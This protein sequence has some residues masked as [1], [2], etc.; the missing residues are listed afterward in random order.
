L[1]VDASTLSAA[2]RTMGYYTP[3]ANQPGLSLPLLIDGIDYPG[4]QISGVDYNQNSGFDV[5]NYDI[6]P[7]DNISF[8][9][10]G[11]VTYDL[12]ILDA[13]YESSYLD[14][15]LGTRPTDVNVDGGAYV[16][17]YS[18]H[19]PEELVPGAEFDTL[20]LRV[21][22]RPGSD[23]EL[24][25]HG[26]PE[27]VVNF[28]YDSSISVY[29][30]ADVLPYPVQIVVYNQ[31]T[32]LELDQNIDCTVDWPAQTVTI[33]SGAT[34]GD[35]ISVS[36]YE[37]G[38]GNQLYK[39]TYN[40]ADI[41]NTVTVPVAF[42]EI[43]EFAIFVNGVYLPIDLNDSTENYAYESFGI[44]QTKITFLN[45]YTSTD[46]ISLVAIGPTLINDAEI[47]YSW[48]V[49]QTQIIT[50]DGV[51]LSY[52]LDNSLIFTN[53]DCL[54]VTVNGARA[55]TAAGVEYI[56]DGST[57]YLLPQRLGF[58]QNTIADNQVHVYVNSIPQVLN[59]DFFVEP[60]ETT[61]LK[62]VIFFTA[63]E[64][65]S[66]IQVYVETGVQCYV[67]NGQLNF[68]PGSGLTPIAGDQ[69]AVTTWNDTR[70][71][72]ILPLVYVGPITT[73]ITVT[74]AYDETLFDN[75]AGLASADP[76]LFDFSAGATV[77][78]NNLQL[79]RIITNPSRLWVSLN[80]RRQFPGVDF[81]ID[82]EE[83]ILHSG[84]LSVTDVVMI[85]MFTES[86]V[87][88]EMAF[89]IFQD[90]RGVQ[91]VYRITPSSTTTL[92]QPVDS[93]DDIVYVA[94]AGALDDPA[95]ELNIWGVVM[96]NGERIMYRERDT[97]NN[98]ISSLLR[99]TAGTAAA[100]HATGS[101]VTDLGRG[102]LLPEEFQNY[103]VTNSILADGIAT[104]FV[105]NDINLLLTDSSVRDR[106]VE[107]YVGGTLVTS[108]YAV[109]ADNPCQITF[110][111]A[112]A[113]GSEVTILVRRGVT[114]YAPGIG[115]PSDGVALQVTN[116]QAARFLRGGP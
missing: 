56:G 97:V 51:S 48:S 67:A 80:G 95:V 111:S 16:D 26:F 42:N 102:N 99:G 23:W 30:F 36:V 45:S 75:P 104:V 81:I 105:A 107:V 71:Q 62:E 24:D 53:P 13:I 74:E 54:I 68:V 110:V 69:I 86:V 87:P 114:W 40:G 115:E 100:N 9:A 59:V 28:D 18:S 27:Q 106:S 46:F 72:N 89:R 64:I 19:A 112:P 88:E 43:Q 7:F 31:T 96:I 11:A 73:G 3:T 57:A 25:G 22:T 78:V 10:T 83:L 33:N 63:P 14:I 20:D 34:T 32:G 85:T 49:P 55:R 29:S 15:Y 65:G 4:V 84:V 41:G 58:S 6:N 44:N 37:L 79:G 61:D 93:N 77:T 1:V 8:E 21:Y 90:M 116:T 108:G 98:T 52:N 5:G 60:F 103:I 66:Q 101:A 17:T 39:Q 50:A 2:D 76:G 113:A 70:Q 38:G 47:N 92:V 109:T 82:G 12:G 35:V 94:N 91:A